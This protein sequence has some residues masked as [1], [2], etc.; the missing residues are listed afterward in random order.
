MQD[1]DNAN[2]AKDVE[3]SKALPNDEVMA[4]ESVILIRFGAGQNLQKVARE[5]VSTVNLFTSLLN[6]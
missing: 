5:I 2:G 4:N 3:A 6:P 1:N